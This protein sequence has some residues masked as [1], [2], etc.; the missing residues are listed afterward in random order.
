MSQVRVPLVVPMVPPSLERQRL[1]S[2][3]VDAKTVKGKA[4]GWLTGVQYLDPGSH[5]I[6][7]HAGLCFSVCLDKAGRLGLPEAERT[8]LNRTE[9]WMRHRDL[10]WQKLWDELRRLSDKAHREGLLAACRLNGTSDIPWEEHRSGLNTLLWWAG[11]VMF[12]DYTKD[13][14]RYLR[15]LER[16]PPFHDNVLRNNYHLTLSWNEKLPQWQVLVEQL[17]CSSIES[18]KGDAGDVVL[19]FVWSGERPSV[20]AGLPVVDGDRHDLTFLY[21]G[22]VALALRAKGPAKKPGRHMGRFV[23]TPDMWKEVGAR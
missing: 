14:Q 19:S 23:V 13:Y 17:I 7:P 8:R 12:Y 18:P 4:H 22:P 6:C 2:V 10:Y 5:S 1:L 21:E 9:L 20:F 16:K 3:G 11:S 15:W